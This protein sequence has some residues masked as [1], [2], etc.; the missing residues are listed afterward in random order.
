M[1]S[2]TLLGPVVDP[3]CSQ[4]GRNVSSFSGLA[5]ATGTFPPNFPIHGC[6]PVSQT[7]D[8]FALLTDHRTTWHDRETKSSTATLWNI[9]QP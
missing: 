2:V 9:T 1:H 5:A 4:T 8:T 7:V 3:V 6:I